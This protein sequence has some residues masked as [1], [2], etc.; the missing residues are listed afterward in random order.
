MKHI[1]GTTVFGSV[2]R[3]RSGLNLKLSQDAIASYHG[4]GFAAGA[5]L[6][7]ELR[8]FFKETSVWGQAELMFGSK[9]FCNSESFT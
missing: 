4:G 8:G 5:R 7:W 1:I 6:L 3:T 9:K 2:V